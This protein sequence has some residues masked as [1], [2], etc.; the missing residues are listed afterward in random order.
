MLGNFKKHSFHIPSAFYSLLSFTASFFSRKPCPVI[1]T[2][3][4]SHLYIMAS[5]KNTHIATLLCFY[6][7][8]LQLTPPLSGEW[9]TN[10]ALT[11]LAFNQ[12][13]KSI[14]IRLWQ[15]LGDV[16]SFFKFYWVL[17][18]YI[19]LK[20]ILIPCDQLLSL[21]CFTIISIYKT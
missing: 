14:V 16:D 2:T 9:N 5:L 3:S 20:F 12:G 7:K 6:D 17:R 21:I 4:F 8:W 15:I 19:L 1:R 11:I 18:N 10:A 13:M